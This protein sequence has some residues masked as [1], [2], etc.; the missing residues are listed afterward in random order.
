MTRQFQVYDTLAA[1]LRN[2]EIFFV[3]AR[4]SLNAIFF[5]LKFL[6]F[7]HDND[8]S[9]RRY[10]FP[11]V[12]FLATVFAARSRVASPCNDRTR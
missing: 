4:Y 10:F 9:T 1:S 12:L 11:L 7:I 6:F 2:A 3:F 5:V 8:S